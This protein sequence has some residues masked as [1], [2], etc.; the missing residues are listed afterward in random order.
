MTS[1]TDKEEFFP[2]YPIRAWFEGSTYAGTYDMSI[3]FPLLPIQI[4]YDNN[5]EPFSLEILTNPHGCNFTWS[6]TRSGIYISKNAQWVETNKSTETYVSR[7]KI[8]DVYISGQTQLDRNSQYYLSVGVLNEDA[9]G[10]DVTTINEGFQFLCGYSDGLELHLIQ[11]EFEQRPFG[12][13]P[14]FVGIDEIHNLANT[15]VTQKVSHRKSIRQE[16]TITITETWTTTTTKTVTINLIFYKKKKTETHTTTHSVS[17][18]YTTIEETDIEIMREIQI[19][20]KT[21][22]QACSTVTIMEGSQ[23]RYT[24]LAMYKARG[25]GPEELLAMISTELKDVDPWIEG[26]DIYF[27]MTDTI[28]YSLAMA[29]SFIVVPYE[30]INGCSSLQQSI[31]TKRKSRRNASLN[32]TSSNKFIKEEL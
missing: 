8:D 4:Q 27:E 21:S 5:T 3:D 15:L 16:T 7:A 2:S 18:S 28:S 17:N 31:S 6:G 9:N 22:V 14:D 23:V 26:N 30:A 29:T 13:Q 1:L 32:D 25:I 19:A 10:T 11:I 12:G 20:P 24:A